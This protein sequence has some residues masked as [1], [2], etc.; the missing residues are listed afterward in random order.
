MTAKEYLLQAYLLEERIGLFRVEQG[1]I[2]LVDPDQHQVVMIKN[3]DDPVAVHGR[4][5]MAFPADLGFFDIFE[6]LILLF[7][8][9][10]GMFEDLLHLLIG[11]LD[12]IFRKRGFLQFLQDFFFVVIVQFRFHDVVA[13][14]KNQAVGGIGDFGL[15][16]LVG[17]FPASGE[18]QGQHH[19][20]QRKEQELFLHEGYLLLHCGFVRTD[21]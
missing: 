1:R 2:G 16:F 5:D 9:L 7:D 4:G 15:E 8:V 10:E 18:E 17:R 21:G 6:L 13:V 3:H 14:N 11:G 20:R 12:H 19:G